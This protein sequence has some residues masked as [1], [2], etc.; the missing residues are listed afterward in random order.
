[1]TNLWHFLPLVIC[2][3][4]LALP[5]SVAGQPSNA[6]GSLT[7]EGKTTNLRYAFA[8]HDTA[9]GF[10]RILITSAPVSTSVLAEEA[11]LP[12]AKAGRTAFR[13]LVANG[14][15][16]AVELFVNGD[17]DMET[18][19]L[20]ENDFNM[21]TL[22]SGDSTFWYEPYRMPAG[23][24]GA[25]SRTR[26]TQEFF[27]NK[28]SY[29]VAYFAPVGPKSFALPSQAAVEAQRKEIDAREKPRIV[30]P[31]GGEEG[32]LYLSFYRNLEA[33]NTK[34][35]LDQ[36][37]ASM[38]KT[39]A[40]EMG[41]AT[42]TAGDLPSWAMMHSTPPAKVEIVGGVRDA[43]GTLLEL[44]KSGTREEFGTARIVKEDGVW[45][46]AEQNW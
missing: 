13:E 40:S 18:A 7:V 4:G 31:G 34:A 16:A 6:S 27:D 8:F 14:Q 35:L 45:K 26:T 5:C 20:F 42:V 37:T 46:V 44:R 9:S 21:P 43:D 23:W 33:V 1:M 29:D 32:A 12:V 28:W 17:G 41:V 24:I 39:L 25:R 22:I 30:Q 10:T 15:I 2:T 36:M 19:R 3:L 38:K 11:V